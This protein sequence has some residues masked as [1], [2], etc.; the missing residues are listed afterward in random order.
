MPIRFDARL[1]DDFW[2]ELPKRVM[3][4]FG[5][6]VRV[7]I[8]AT[9]NGFT[10]RTTIFSMK[11]CVGIPVRRE[12]QHGAGIEAGSLI[13]VELEEDVSPRT[14]ALPPALRKALRS[15]A[16]RDGFDS[17]SYTRRKELVSAIKGAKKPETQAA[18]VEKAVAAALAARQ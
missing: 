8:R 2:I 12:V 18:R 9:L 15:K 16:L 1:K 14:V 17:L 11:G 13:K 10:Y 5:G 7:K 6:R 3:D 4:S